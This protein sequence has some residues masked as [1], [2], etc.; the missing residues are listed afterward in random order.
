MATPRVDRRRSTS[1]PDGGLKGREG[2][3]RR[4][5]LLESGEGEQRQS[6]VERSV[7]GDAGN[8][9]LSQWRRW[10]RAWG[11][12]C[13]VAAACV[14]DA[15]IVEQVRRE[16]VRL[17]EDGLLSE[18]VREAHDVAA[19]DDSSDGGA[20]AIGQRGDRLL[21]VGEVG[22]AAEGSVVN[23]EGAVD[24]DVELVLVVGV[25]GG[26][27]VVVG[28]EA[29]SDYR[30]GESREQCDGGGVEGRGDDVVEELLARRIGRPRTT[31]VVPGL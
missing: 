29:R 5:K 21:D 18:D 16:R 9:K 17:I 15:Q 13:R 7:G 20:A 2:A 19:A 6:V 3:G 31:V 30:R 28:G 26:A 22:V 1:L 25:V 24:A 11:R 4:P 27:S 8:T 14:A 12:R 10:W 23:A